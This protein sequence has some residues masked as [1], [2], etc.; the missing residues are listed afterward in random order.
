MKKSDVKIG[1]TYTAE[2][3]DK[4]VNV[5]IDSE[6]RHGGWDATN[7][8]TGKKIRIKSPAR[9]RSAKGGPKSATST[10][11]EKGTKEPKAKTGANTAQTGQPRAKKPKGEKNLSGLDAAA[12]VLQESGKEL[13]VKEI[14]D[15]ILTKGYWKSPEGKTPRA[16]IYSS[17]IREIA[18]KGKDSRFRKA[19]RG[20]FVANK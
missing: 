9:L 20:K 19:E 2:V 4:V 12:K 13:N 1:H 14:L 6:S 8:A 5:R 11:K 10:K 16:T 15:A 18:A 7:L 17:I 3:T